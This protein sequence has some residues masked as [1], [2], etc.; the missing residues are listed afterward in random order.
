MRLFLV[1][2]AMLVGASIQTSAQNAATKTFEL[3][4]QQ[5][6]KQYWDCL[7]GETA[8]VAS[9]KMRQQDFVTFI[10]SACLNEQ[11]QF[12]NAL[13]KLFSRKQNTDQQ[14]VYAAVD[15]IIAASMDDFA[16]TKVSP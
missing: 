9:R 8:K 2:I 13:I 15:R 10:K 3:Q 1:I 6:K 7:S 16:R 4:A 12:R 11:A 14:M 5:T